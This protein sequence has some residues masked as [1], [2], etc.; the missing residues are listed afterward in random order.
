MIRSGSP[1]ARRR[2]AEQLYQCN[3]RFHTLVD[4]L[5]AGQVTDEFSAEQLAAAVALAKDFS[6]RKKG[7]RPSTEAWGVRVPPPEDAG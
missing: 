4:T 3:P 1:T 2:D 7:K 6:D 5:V